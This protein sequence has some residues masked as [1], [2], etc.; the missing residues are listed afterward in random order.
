MSCLI[1]DSE[2]D[3][4]PAS[5]VPAGTS[6]GFC[7]A[8]WSSSLRPLP[9]AINTE[10]QRGLE[11]ETYFLLE[12]SQQQETRSLSSLTVASPNSKG[13]SSDPAAHCWDASREELLRGRDHTFCQAQIRT[14]NRAFGFQLLAFF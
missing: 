13:H 4:T 1:L 10:Q 2:P 7:R 12:L 6:G 9:R 11:E 5:L 8:A 14:G 3:A